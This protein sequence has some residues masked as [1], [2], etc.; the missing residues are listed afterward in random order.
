M[1]REEHVITDE[2]LARVAELVAKAASAQRRDFVLVPPPPGVG[3][4]GFPG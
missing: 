4:S 2:A 3:E 1:I